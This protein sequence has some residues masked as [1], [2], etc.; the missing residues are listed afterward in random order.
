MN[1]TRWKAPNT[2][3]ITGSTSAA[4]VQTGKGCCTCDV[5]AGPGAAGQQPSHLSSLCRALQEYLWPCA[6]ACRRAGAA[7]LLNG[8]LRGLSV[9]RCAPSEP[10]PLRHGSSTSL[11]GHQGSLND[12]GVSA[13]SLTYVTG[14]LMPQF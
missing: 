8:P 3:A 12:A 2:A 1:Q 13:L 5:A 9:E 11:V 14:A 10:P 6:S 4:G 7:P